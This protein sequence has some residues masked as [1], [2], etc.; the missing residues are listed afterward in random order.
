MLVTWPER[1]GWTRTMNSWNHLA[2]VAGF[3]LGLLF[4]LRLVGERR[5]PSV[6]LTWLLGV[7]VAPYL[8]VPLFLM[9]SGRKLRKQLRGKCTLVHRPA[10][11]PGHGLSADM[12][13]LL[14]QE[15]AGVL[16]QGSDMRL[17][18]DGVAAY[19]SLVR[20][21]EGAQRSIHLTTFIL[22]G[23]EVGQE[24]RRLLR[25]KA[26]SGVEV[27][28]L[29]DALGSF[30]TKGRF[31]D[32]LRRAGAEV[33]AF[34]PVLPL[35][36]R[37][38]A[39]LRNHRKVVVV[40][41]EVA[42]TG[43][44]NLALEYLG[45]EP[46]ESR[47]IDLS[48]ELR[49]PI[50]ADLQCVFAD[51]WNFATEGDLLPAEVPR[52]VGEQA[53]QI[54]ASGPDLPGDPLSDVVLHAISNAQESIWIV[55]PYFILDDPIER[56]LSLAARTGRDVR[57]VL[58]ERSNHKLADLARTR[59]QYDLARDGVRFLLLPDQMI[60]AKAMVFDG[61]LGIFG[62]ANLDLRSLYLNFELSV[63][64]HGGPGLE[65]LQSW[66][67][68]LAARTRRWEARSPR[69]KERVLADITDLAA[70]LL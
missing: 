12:L 52:A 45:P 38:S 10:V 58:P 28:V 17:L 39:N 25:E 26:E 30:R 49:G 1:A 6:T 40:D 16:R 22:G 36:R 64:L 42:W 4:V 68:E 67:E 41:G 31:L 7:V 69:L 48:A 44:R 2:A 13:R 63:L 43:G 9:F 50:V 65:Q 27:R 23:D 21:I 37:S 62:S 19:Q 57:V 54:V 18:H 11:E 5:K 66:I 14:D 47:W 55:T 46:L 33:A 56:A 20:L 35:H 51:D 24:V 61:E 32:P 53:A 59:L 34:L 15:G 60:H 70:P 3:G 29:V 8:V